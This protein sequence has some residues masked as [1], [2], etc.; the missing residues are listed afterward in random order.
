MSIQSLFVRG[1]PFLLTPSAA[2]HA[3]LA[4]DAPA[5]VLGFNL[6]IETQ[7]REFPC[8]V[9]HICS[10]EPS[11]NFFAYL[12][13]S[14]VSQSYCQA[15]AWKALS[16]WT[17]T[18]ISV[19]VSEL[20]LLMCVIPTHVGLFSFSWSRRARRVSTVMMILPLN[21]IAAFLSQ[22][23]GTRLLGWSGIAGSILQI[24]TMR[25]MAKRSQRRI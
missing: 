22:Q 5:A 9:D 10:C 7:V 16:F 17:A 1:A 19:P 21:I 11:N 6:A 14:L 20:V 12:L 4:Q 18:D 24:M 8:S 25:A 13:T 23:I 15:K 2:A 3:S